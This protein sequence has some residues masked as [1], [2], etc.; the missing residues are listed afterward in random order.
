MEEKL[1][2]L[3]ADSLVPLQSLDFNKIHLTC[4][5]A[6]LAQLSGYHGALV[7]YLD[8][9]SHHSHWQQKT[10][11]TDSATTD[12]G[13]PTLKLNSTAFPTGWGTEMLKRSGGSIIA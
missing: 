10:E 13:P 6:Q 9:G 11:L 8:S 5:S 4:S 1:E 7:L 3:F 12:W 2:D